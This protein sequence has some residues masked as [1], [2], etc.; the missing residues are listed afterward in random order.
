[1]RTR[2]AEVKYSS[3]NKMLTVC[4]H[5]DGWERHRQEEQSQLACFNFYIP[6]TLFG[7]VYACIW[8]KTSKFVIF[9]FSVW[10]CSGCVMRWYCL[11]ASLNDLSLRLRFSAKCTGV[12]HCACCSGSKSRK[13]VLE[14]V[15]TEFLNVSPFYKLHMIMST[16][17]C[18]FSVLSE[19]SSFE[20]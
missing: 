2:K 9:N 17:V 20:P 16:G 15:K 3:P 18:T 7:I 1:M 11:D 4:G 13:T 19:M 6:Y 10:S 5:I 12:K 14:W 8:T